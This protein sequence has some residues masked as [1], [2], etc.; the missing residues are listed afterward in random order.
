MDVRE[1]RAHRLEVVAGIEALGDRDRLTE[2]LAVAQEGGAGEHIDL[3]AGIVDVVLARH[4]PAGGGEQVRER[5][6]EHRAA[7]VADMHRPGGVGRDVLDVDRTARHLSAP[8]RLALAERR[9]DHRMIDVRREPQVDEAGAGHARLD[10]AG[11]GAQFACQRLAERLGVLPG[12]LRQHQGGVGGQIPVR[13][14]ARRLDHDPRQVEALRQQA[15]AGER[16]E[17]LA[18]ARLEEGEDV[19]GAQVFVV[20]AR[21]L[22]RASGGRTRR[23]RHSNGGRE[24]HGA[25]APP[26]ASSASTARS[27]SGSGAGRRV[28]RSTVTWTKCPWAA[29]SA[30]SSRK[31]A[32]S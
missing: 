22:A 20:S 3:R 31:I 26:G 28:S 25:S 8:E 27:R 7:A 23:G 14:V 11:I 30:S 6:A 32:I 16:F 13:G 29:A 4:R 10:D 9:P 24:C 17:R 21:R 19:H 18:H 15:G 12:L 5:V 2:R 1:L